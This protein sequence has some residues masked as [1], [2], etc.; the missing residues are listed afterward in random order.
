[1]RF[2][3]DRGWR[4]ISIMEYDYT[5]EEFTRNRDIRAHVTGWVPVPGRKHWCNR[6]KDSIWCRRTTEGYRMCSD[7]TYRPHLPWKNAPK[8]RY[9]ATQESLWSLMADEIEKIATFEAQREEEALLG[10]FEYAIVEGLREAGVIERD[11]EEFDFDQIEAAIEP[12]RKAIAAL[13]SN[14]AMLRVITRAMNDGAPEP[15]PAAPPAPAEPAPRRINWD[16]FQ[17]IT[18]DEIWTI[19][20]FEVS[21]ADRPLQRELE[22]SVLFGL[23]TANIIPWTSTTYNKRDIER[24]LDEV[25]KSISVNMTNDTIV[26]FMTRVLNA[27]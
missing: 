14:E 8:A 11:E 20:T 26:A 5:A 24:G 22:D 17:S 15:A 4:P 27:A 19:M 21:D 25:R 1:M 6:C 10:R 2:A 3:Y 13:G 18:A 9:R 12:V 7:E 23:R 16:Y